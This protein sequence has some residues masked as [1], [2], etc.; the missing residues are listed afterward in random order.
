VFKLKQSAYENL[1]FPDTMTYEMRSEL[2]KECSRFLR[3]S[4]L[5]DFIGL[6]ALRTI[7]KESVSELLIEF[8]ELVE[9][10]SPIVFK[11]RN[12]RPLGLKQKEPMFY[13]QV[14]HDFIPVEEKNFVI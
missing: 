14:E 5:I 1:G 8:E 12:Q 2:R 6:E 4:Y 13:L 10:D 11:E 9:Y 3:F 7:Y